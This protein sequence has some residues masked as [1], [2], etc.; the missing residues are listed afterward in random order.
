MQLYTDNNNLKAI[1]SRLEEFLSED[2]Q[3]VDQVSA[4]ILDESKHRDLIVEDEE[5][6]FLDEGKL[7]IVKS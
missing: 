4:I 7:D 1:G 2:K 6:D 5:E 3:N